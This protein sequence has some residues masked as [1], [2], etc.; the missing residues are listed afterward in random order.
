MPVRPVPEG[1]PRVSPYL[2]VDD[3]AGLIDFMVGVFDAE[4]LVRHLTSDGRV[5]HAE[6]RVVDSVLMVGGANAQWPAVPAALH[7][8]VEDVDA[9]YARAVAATATAL[10]SPV[11][12][13]YGD[14]SA[15]VISPGG[16]AWFI[17]THV[18]DVTDDEMA[19]RMKAAQSPA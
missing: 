16:V 15:H 4:V 8:Y 18:E 13:F 2:I 7:I 9:V 10:E 1:R 3:A 19:R 17:T 11:T 12:K 5:M 6:V 14:R